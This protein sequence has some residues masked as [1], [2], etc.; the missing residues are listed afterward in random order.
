[1]AKFRKKAVV[2]EAVQYNGREDSI[3]K[4]LALQDRPVNL[5]RV[6]TDGL[7]INN[8]EGVMKANKH[9]WI[10]K[11]VNGELYLLPPDIFAR[12]YEPFE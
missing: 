1:M 10:I 3:I 2:I 12:T 6:E 9:D 11:G 8:P 5:I 7:R 4:I